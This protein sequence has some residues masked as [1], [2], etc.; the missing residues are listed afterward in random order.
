MAKRICKV[1]VVEDN[2]FIRELLEQALVGDGYRFDA[3]ANGSQMRAKL[4][5]DEVYDIAV[6]DYHLPGD[7]NGIT[8]AKLAASYGLGVIL[9]SG[10]GEESARDAMQASGHA[11]LQKP[12][13]IK[14]LLAAVEAALLL[15]K[16]HCERDENEPSEPALA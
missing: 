7:S 4:E 10:T 2:S 16:R 1:L 13:R 14:E 9:V 12:F 3:V 15:A 8:L 11:F 6:I 5:T